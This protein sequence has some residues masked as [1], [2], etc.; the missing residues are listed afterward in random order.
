MVTHTV[1]G[2]NRA[3]HTFHLEPTPESVACVLRTW[4][5]V[6]SAVRRRK[7]VVETSHAR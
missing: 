3:G 7:P 2:C 5:S 1:P 6:T 4:F